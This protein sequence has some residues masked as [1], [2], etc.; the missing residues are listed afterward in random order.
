MRES[1]KDIL[2]KAQIFYV[3]LSGSEYTFNKLTNTVD[4]VGN[5]VKSGAGNFI[6]FDNYANESSYNASGNTSSNA[7]LSVWQSSGLISLKP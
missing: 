7:S 3:K 2:P 1:V 4:G 5:E 6:C